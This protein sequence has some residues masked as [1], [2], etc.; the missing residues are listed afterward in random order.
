MSGDSYFLGYWYMPKREAWI[1][2]NRVVNQFV[3]NRFFCDN[4]NLCTACGLVLYAPKLNSN[5]FD[6]SDVRPAGPR[7]FRPES[8]LSGGVAMFHLFDRQVDTSLRALRDMRLTTLLC[9]GI[10]NPFGPTLTGIFLLGDPETSH[11]FDL[12]EITL[13][14]FAQPTSRI[15]RA[16]IEPDWNASADYEA[17]FSIPFGKC[18]TLMLPTSLL[19]TEAAINIHARWLLNFPDAGETWE[20]VRRY[21]ADPWNRVSEEIEGGLQRVGQNTRAQQREGESDHRLKESEA[22]EFAIFALSKEHMTAELQAFFF[23]WKG[24]I[25][26]QREQGSRAIASEAL[27]FDDFCTWFSLIAASCRLPEVGD[28]RPAN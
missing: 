3:I 12:V 8:S 9:G 23:A 16:L 15:G 6:K 4:E 2:K 27:Q 11:E 24:S 28:A 18:P 1:M 14:P 21:P 26:L 25:N 19:T 17:L 7:L 13:N 22:R 20:R 10:V 5:Y